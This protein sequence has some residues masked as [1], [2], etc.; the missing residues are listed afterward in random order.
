MWISRKEYNFLKENAE[1]NIDAECEIMKV[2][3]RQKCAVARAMEE[4]SAVLEQL[5]AL[6][7]SHND[8]YK[9]FITTL[10]TIN[11][12]FKFINM[13]LN[14][15]IKTEDGEESNTQKFSNIKAFAIY[16]KSANDI[17]IKYIKEK[18]NKQY[19]YSD[20]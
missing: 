20:K 15:T 13:I 10:M 7:K 12:N 4:Y 14:E 3:H 17:N 1:K 19:G 11:S 18:L 9:E 6:K 5:D 2:E 16:L 8:I